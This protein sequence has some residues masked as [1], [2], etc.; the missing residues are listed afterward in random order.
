MK[1]AT[2]LDLLAGR[3]NFIT[4]QMTSRVRIEGEAMAGMV[5]EGI[6]ASFRARAQQSGAAAL[7]A[8]LFERWFKNSNGGSKMRVS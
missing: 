6:V 5:L 4:A 7:P 1:A 8:R 2:M 3:Q